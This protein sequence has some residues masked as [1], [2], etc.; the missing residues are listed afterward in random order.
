MHK[1]AKFSAISDKVHFEGLVHL[2]I[3]IKYNK[4][5]GLKYYADMNDEP[6]SDLLVQNSIKTENHLMDCSDFFWQDCTD[7]GKSTVEYIIFYQGGP[8]DHGTHVPLQVDLSS[9]ERDYNTGCTGGM[10]LAHFR[11]LIHELLSKNP[12]IIPEDAPLIVLDSKSAMCMSNNGK[13][14][15]HYRHIGRRIHFVRSG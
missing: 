9:E 11:M 12:D 1:L 2:L 14:N 6:V 8:I 10:S 5:L 7:T 3:Y 4:T 13:D 15:K